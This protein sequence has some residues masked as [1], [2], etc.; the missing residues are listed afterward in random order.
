[1]VT[2]SGQRLLLEV[3]ATGNVEIRFLEDDATFFEVV[4]TRLGPVLG[5]RN[6]LSTGHGG[7][8]CATVSRRRILWIAGP[9]GRP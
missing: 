2:Q 1:M 9:R 5:D 7:D 6:P 4:R 3:T 8:P